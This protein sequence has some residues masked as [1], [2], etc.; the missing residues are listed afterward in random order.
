MIKDENLR[1]YEALTHE[2]A[3]DAAERRELT[4]EQRAGS[5]RL[6]AY[7]HAQLAELER[8]DA[9]RVRCVRPAIQAMQRPSLLE[10]LAEIFRAQP[11]VVFAHRDFE[12]LSDDDLRSA[13][14]D[15]ESMIERMA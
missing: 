8:A 11:R 2:A 4:P 5:R 10:R 1:T 13:L 6:L 3:M 9:R 7:A 15:A 14:E 12:R